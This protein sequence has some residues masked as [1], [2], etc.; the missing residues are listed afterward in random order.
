LALQAAA[1]IAGA[2]ALERGP[3]DQ[4]R[5]GLLKSLVRLGVKEALIVDSSPYDRLMRRFHN[6]MKDTPEFQA[7]R[8]DY[9]ELRFPPWSAWMVF[10]D[11]VSHASISGVC[12]REYLHHPPG[13]LSPPELAPIN[14][15]R[16]GTSHSS[17]VRLSA[18]ADA[19]ARRP[20]YVVDA[21][22]EHALEVP[23]RHSRAKQGAGERAIEHARA[24]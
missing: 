20:R 7:G 2:H 3:L 4:V 14:I 15:L 5:T 8:D 13:I 12:A 19:A 6:Y 24:P 11:A 9:E 18:P 21:D 23:E 10:T 17:S 22:A 1:G 16:T